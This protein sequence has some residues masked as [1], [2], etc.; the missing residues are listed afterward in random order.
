MKP[1]CQL[2]WR[3]VIVDADGH[4]AWCCNACA[5]NLHTVVEASQE[6]QWRANLAAN[7]AAAGMAAWATE[8]RCVCQERLNWCRSCRA[9]RT[10][11]EAV[12]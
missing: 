4:A 6:S 7:L 8:S 10:M 2:C 3:D 11:R 9:Y 1:C 12:L 5:L